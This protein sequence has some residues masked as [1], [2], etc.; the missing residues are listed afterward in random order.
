[1]SDQRTRL[2]GLPD[3]LAG[4]GG[5]SAAWP[6]R[7][8]DILDL[9]SREVYGFAPP[10]PYGMSASVTAYE[11]NAFA[12][13]ATQTT[14]ELSFDPPDGCVR[15]DASFG[16]F[17][18]SFHLIVP[19]TSRPPLFLH[20]AFRPDI[21]DRY[22][23][24]EEILDEGF[25]LATFCYLDVA[26]DEDDGFAGGM[27]GLYSSA[28]RGPDSWGKIAMWAWAASRVMDVLQTLPELDPARMAVIG[29]SRLGKTALWC[30]ALDERFALT[31]C[32]EPGCSG[33][34]ITR[35][36]NGEHIHH[37]LSRFGYWFCDNYRR[38][39]D[40][41]DEMPFDQHF[42]LACIAPRLLYNGSAV[43]DEWSDPDAEFQGCLE[44]DPVYRLL[45]VPGL[46]GP[47]AGYPAGPVR[48]AYHE[49]SIGYHLRE[50]NH[51]LSRTDWGQAMAYWKK[52]GAIR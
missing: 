37:I 36:K 35:G 18:F 38:Y 24:V 43:L 12:G 17:S 23:P 31:V 51:F 25:A 20:I 10:P 14:Y 11:D 26:P 7:R 30:S 32:N 3:V 15:Q 48:Q 29:H 39:A 1:M 4:T 19:K 27:A 45:G 8:A 47:S 2:P 44:A 9:L 5:L 22:C 34:A 16:R 6:A 46:D 49:G 52:H 40:R 28:V 50:G 33:S 13:K 42:L 21:P 41:E